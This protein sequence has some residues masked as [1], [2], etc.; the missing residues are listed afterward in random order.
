MVVVLTTANTI[1]EVWCRLTL[2]Y[3]REAGEAYRLRLRLVYLSPEVAGASV[4]YSDIEQKA[5]MCS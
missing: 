1:T 3:T 2:E 4:K 5:R